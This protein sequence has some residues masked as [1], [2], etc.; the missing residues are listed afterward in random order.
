MFYEVLGFSNCVGLGRGASLSSGEET[1]VEAELVSTDA[2]SSG[3]EIATALV[4]GEATSAAGNSPLGPDMR[5]SDR[6]PSPE[7]WAP[8]WRGGDM[9]GERGMSVESVVSPRCR[10]RVAETSPT[11]SYRWL[12]PASRST[13]RLELPGVEGDD[14]EAMS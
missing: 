6:V 11:S 9:G 5:S 2:E 8:L 10:R 4:F 12:R 14:V 13:S 3:S 7:T 1:S